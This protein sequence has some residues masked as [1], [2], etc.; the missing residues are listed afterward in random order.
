MP[1]KKVK[2]LFFLHQGPAVGF[3]VPPAD[4]ELGKVIIL[5]FF[6]QLLCFLIAVVLLYVQVTRPAASTNRKTALMG[7]EKDGFIEVPL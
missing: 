6:E 1:H 7:E 5:V 3:T 2:F 4:T